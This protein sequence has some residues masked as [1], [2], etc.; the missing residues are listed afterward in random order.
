MYRDIKLGSGPILLFVTKLKPRRGRTRNNSV[1]TK[2]KKDKV[3]PFSWP[4][5]LGLCEVWGF[6]N[7]P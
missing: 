7:Y 2:Q 6:I 4:H 1:K 5:A 3:C